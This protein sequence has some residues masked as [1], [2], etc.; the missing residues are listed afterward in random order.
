[1]LLPVTSPLAYA[2]LVV[3]FTHQMETFWQTPYGALFGRAA[4]M[5]QAHPWLGLGWNGFRDDC[6]QPAYLHGVSWLPIANPA[7]PDG[8]NIHPH[9]DWLQVATIGGLPAQAL[10]AA[11][12]VLRLRRIAG[13]T[14][15][16]NSGRR[17]ALLV[18]VFVMLWPVASATSL[19]TVPNAGWFCLL[20]GW[21]LAEARSPVNAGSAVP[22]LR[23]PAAN[24]GARATA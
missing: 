7:S 9:N 2:K 4:T 16:L 20:V 10:F 11:L 23:H 22:S 15:Y 3:H 24:T 21:G 17:L 19:F 14:A 8:C 18:V 12:A 6:M 1:M 5:I 13:G